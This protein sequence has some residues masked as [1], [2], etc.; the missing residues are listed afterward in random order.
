VLLLLL[1]LL[2]LLFAKGKSKTRNVGTI[3]A[4]PTVFYFRRYNILWKTE[5]RR[6]FLPKWGLATGYRNLA[7]SGVIRYIFFNKRVKDGCED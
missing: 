5:L 1:L 3:F 4:K 6:L 2:L 7:I